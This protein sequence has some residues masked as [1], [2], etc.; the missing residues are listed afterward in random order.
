[1]LKRKLAIELLLLFVI[2]PIVLSIPNITLIKIIYTVLVALYVFY[3]T[4][5][6][7]RIVFKLR[8]QIQPHQFWKS[9]LFK[10]LAISIASVA[11]LY[12]VNPELVFNPIKTNI[13]L[14]IKMLLVYAFI[15]VVPQEY[16]Y[17]VFFFGRYRKLFNNHKL[18]IA[19]NVFTFS[20]AHLFF[21]NAL[22]ILMTLIGGLLFAITYSKTK[23]LLWVSAEHAIYGGWLFTAGLGTMLGFP[24]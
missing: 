24:I 6:Y 16:I 20:L 13:S 14:W 18:L 8:K 15:S 5:K 17:R 4:Y 19:A 1:M 2:Y 11:Y 9:T 10:L 23:S 12:I 22:V 7:R 3:L 21:H